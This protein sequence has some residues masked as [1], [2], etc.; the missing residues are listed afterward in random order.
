MKNKINIEPQF[1]WIEEHGIMTCTLTDGKHEF[2]GSAKCAPEDIDMKSEKTG[3]K[4]ALLRAE[5]AYFRY[6][7]D[8]EI[9]PGLKALNQVYYTMKHSSHFNEKS[10]EYKM[11]RRQINF[12]E[13]DLILIK[14]MI[15]EKYLE[16][17]AYLKAK[18][19]FYK[20]IRE[21]RMRKENGDGYFEHFNTPSTEN[22]CEENSAN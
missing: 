16:L 22:S 13:D 10:Y 5:M 14:N 15:A 8:N 12:Y 19:K 20:I 3:Y 17:T 11:L 4:I 21:T 6:I 2:V 18:N 7:R 9:K 1:D